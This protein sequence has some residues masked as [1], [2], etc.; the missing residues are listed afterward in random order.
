MKTIIRIKIFFFDTRKFEEQTNEQTKKNVFG[1][2]FTNLNDDDVF[3]LRH[4]LMGLRGWLVGMS[5][6]NM[7]LNLDHHNIKKM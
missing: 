6:L 4:K 3:F 7:N 2:H 1:F 5:M